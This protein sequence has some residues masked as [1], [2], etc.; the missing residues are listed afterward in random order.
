[1]TQHHT[2]NQANKTTT[3]SVLSLS[4]SIVMEELFDEW[5]DEI[6][7][8]RTLIV[9]LEEFFFADS[10]PQVIEKTLEQTI[11]KYIDDQ[12]TTPQVMNMLRG[13]QLQIDYYGIKDFDA[14]A[15]YFY[16]SKAK[17]SEFIMYY[18]KQKAIRYK[19]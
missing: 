18:E 16:S 17:A 10:P 3:S 1:M 6:K 14:L 11:G 5:V 13:T 15:N 12:S 9:L 7:Q 4:E 8:A 19:K 2:E